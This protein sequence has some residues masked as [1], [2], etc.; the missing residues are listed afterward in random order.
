MGKFAW[1]F[2]ILQ[3]ILWFPFYPIRIMGECY[4]M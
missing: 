2:L 4:R 1:F 3:A